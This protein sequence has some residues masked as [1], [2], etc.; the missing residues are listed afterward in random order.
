[1]TDNALKLLILG[2]GR[3]GTALATGLAAD[4]TRHMDIVVLDPNPVDPVGLS[5]RGIRVCR[6]A[7]SLPA[8]NEWRAEHVICALKPQIMRDTLPSY[9][10]WMQASET[11]LSVAAGF[12]LAALE[13][14]G[15]GPRR[16]I[17]LMPNLPV[18]QGFGVIGAC[19][20]QVPPADI[21]R[22][23]DGLLSPLGT[24]YWL[25]HEEEIDAITAIAGSGPAYVFQFVESLAYAAQQLGF[26]PDTA[27]SI[28]RQTLVGAAEMLKAPD[29]SAAQLRNNVTSPGGTTEAALNTLMA[30]DALSR[31]LSSTLQAAF[32]RARQLAKETS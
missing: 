5:E 12:S 27:S 6:S 30:D 31:L 8:P 10:P 22:M 29:A 2:A 25:H 20:K 4:Q 26:E 14:L 32:D 9:R 24:I 13:A 11:F 21:R 7:A 16:L 23:V 15:P 17:R 3:M 28:A 18:S 19:A 1:M